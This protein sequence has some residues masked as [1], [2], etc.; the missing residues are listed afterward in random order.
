LKETKFSR[1]KDK[2]M[3]VK[4]SPEAYDRLVEV[5]TMLEEVRPAE[6]WS[7]SDAVLLMYKWSGPAINEIRANGQ[8]TKGLTTKKSSLLWIK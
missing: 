2:R 3:D 6:S 4:V 7:M 1:I 8:R 5:R